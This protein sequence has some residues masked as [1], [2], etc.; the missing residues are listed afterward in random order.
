MFKR[1]FVG[2]RGHLVWAVLWLA[3]ASS[4]DTFSIYVENDSRYLKPNHNTDRHYTSGV[5]LVWGFEPNWRWVEE[6]GDL[7]VPFFSAPQGPVKTGAGVFLGQ[8]IYTPD[9]VDEPARRKAKDMRYA[10]WLSSGLFVQ[11][12]NERF[13]DQAELSV[14]VVGP[15]ALGREVQDCIHKAMHSGRPIGWDEQLG[16]RPAVQLSWFRRGRLG[17]LGNSS[18]PTMDFLAEYGVAGGSILC[19]VQASL[20]GRLGFWGLPEDWGP[21]RLDLPLGLMG[22]SFREQKTGYIFFRLGG[23]AVGYNQFL[24]GLDPE[25]AVGHL[26]V[27]CVIQIRSLSLSYSQ[28]FLTQEYKEQNFFDGYGGISIQWTF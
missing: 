28:T 9:W 2:G 21:D 27:G 16:D 14:G 4:A 11:R 18:N 1:L 5:K 10:G 20:I 25:P 6:F 13:L 12:A 23:K 17:S 19:H 26:Q 3:G 8:N 24:T 22:G 15:S 7:D